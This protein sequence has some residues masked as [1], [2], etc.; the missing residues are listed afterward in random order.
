MTED[1]ASVRLLELAAASAEIYDADI[2]L[3]SGD[4]SDVGFGKI[5]ET[6][7]TTRNRENIVLVMTTNGGSANSAY[8]IARFIQK[9]YKKFYLYAPSYCKSA[10]TIVALGAHELIMDPFSE[11]GPL[12][13]QLLKQ[14]ELGARKSGL[15]TKSAFEGLADASLTVFERLM[16]PIM[17]KSGGLVNFQLAAE[18]SSTMTAAMMSTIFA[19]LDPD[20][21]GSDKRDLEVAFDYGIRL[22]EKSGNA[23]HATVM[24][25]VQHY[26]AHDFIID[27]EEASDLFENVS[28]PDPNLMGLASLLGS[29]AYDES[30]DVQVISL[31]AMATDQRSDDNE[32]S[33]QEEA[34][35]NGDGVHTARSRRT[36]RK[37]N[38][39]S[40]GDKDEDIL[41][42]NPVNAAPETDL[43][44]G[45][46]EGTPIKD[47]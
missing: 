8:Q 20:T 18:L 46:G 17:Q 24:H 36:D 5:V 45:N 33:T 37:G 19:K 3:Y 4:I 42:D 21:V 25:L 22:I 27:D 28:F 13:V 15:L 1:E 10:G 29:R 26:P 38:S 6:I 7:L 32:R 44:G 40:K 41:T 2:I 16:L 43:A 31:S 14:N 11:L 47:A 34:A 12:D 23:S 39:K 35:S 30:E 9:V